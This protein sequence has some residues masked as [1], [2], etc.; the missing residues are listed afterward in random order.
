MRRRVIVIQ[1]DDSLHVSRERVLFTALAI[2]DRA[3]IDAFGAAGQPVHLA[4]PRLAR[5]RAELRARRL[6][7]P[8]V[9]VR[10]AA[11]SLIPRS[12]SCV[13]VVSVISQ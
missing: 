13:W 10:S 7:L 1:A 2:H 6:S 9:A 12:R 3:Q 11:R 8:A 5:R 4:A